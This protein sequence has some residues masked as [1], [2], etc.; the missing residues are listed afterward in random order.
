M[1]SE[2][3]TGPDIKLMKSVDKAVHVGGL[4][5]RSAVGATRAGEIPGNK[6]LRNLRKIIMLVIFYASSRFLLVKTTCD[7]F[8]QRH[9]C[10]AN[11]NNLRGAR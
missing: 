11:K 6:E 9:C 8:S 1:L 7:L 4:E 2:C 3:Q 10:H 5:D